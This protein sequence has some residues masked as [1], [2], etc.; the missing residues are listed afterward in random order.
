MH[1][2]IV[3][4]L[5][6]GNAVRRGEFDGRGDFDDLITYRISVIN[7]SDCHLFILP[8]LSD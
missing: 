6:D 1:V 4:H 5:S 2:T 7:S 8:C 3:T